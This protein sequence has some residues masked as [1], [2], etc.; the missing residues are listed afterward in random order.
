MSS[1]NA[2]PLLS[3]LR[4]QWAEV[5]PGFHVATKDGEFA[6]SV[7]TTHDGHFVALDARSTP[8]GRYE[9]LAEAK[10]SLTTTLPPERRELETRVLSTL[11][12]AAVMAG[13]ASAIALTVGTASLLT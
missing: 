11:Q 8:I 10:R 7:D 12:T 4:L 6:G 1:R 3:G 5:D 13:G 9:T 2:A